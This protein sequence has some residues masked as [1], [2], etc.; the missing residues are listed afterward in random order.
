MAEVRADDDTIRRFVVMHYR[1][2]PDRRERRNVVVAAFDNEAEFQTKI[3]SLAADLRAQRESDDPPD[4]RE[5]I[6]GVVLE[7]GH[8]A[9]QRNARL[10]IRAVRHGAVARATRN[11]PM[12]ATQATLSADQK[13]LSD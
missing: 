8:H 7:P 9:L 4:T 1:Y 5:R 3:N 10:L 13:D 11:L 12:P 2:D 6:S